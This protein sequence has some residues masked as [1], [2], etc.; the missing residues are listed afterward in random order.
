[1][2]D[3]KQL[4]NY[5]QN[6]LLNSKNEQKSN[7]EDSTDKKKHENT[8]RKEKSQFQQRF[9]KDGKINQEKRRKFV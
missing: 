3:F 2:I 6:H 8:D 4:N 1:M 5:E 7:K 9:M